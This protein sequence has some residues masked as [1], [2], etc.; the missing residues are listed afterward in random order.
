MLELAAP[1]QMVEAGGQLDFGCD[2]ALGLGDEAADVAASYVA[3]NG[4]AAL[5]PFARDGRRAFHDVD[6]CQTLE[7][8]ALAG[9]SR[10][11]NRTD[12]LGIRSQALRQAHDERK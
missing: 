5:A 1:F 4:N 10:N 11:E 9:R 12:R 3:R 2:P 7:R 8:N 6:R